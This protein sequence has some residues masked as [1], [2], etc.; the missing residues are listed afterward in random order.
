MGFRSR[1]QPGKLTR[2]APPWGALWGESL[3]PKHRTLGQQ[4]HKN[5]PQRGHGP[6]PCPCSS[7]LWGPMMLTRIPRKAAAGLGGPGAADRGGRGSSRGPQGGADPVSHF[8]LVPEARS[9]RPG[10]T[11]VKSHRGGMCR[12]H[13]AAPQGREQGRPGRAA[14]GAGTRGL[15]LSVC[16]LPYAPEARLLGPL[17]SAG[18]RQILSR[19]GSSR[20]LSCHIMLRRSD[21][22]LRCRTCPPPAALQ[23]PG[24]CCSVPAGE[25]G[26]LSQADRGWHPQEVT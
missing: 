2:R 7:P 15:E 9:T 6:G 11:G 1:L 24:P 13:H 22:G 23:G 10:L 3:L 25:T 17:W 8:F 5:I 20:V 16:P 26:C 4:L 18:G 14:D 21:V 12:R 19:Q